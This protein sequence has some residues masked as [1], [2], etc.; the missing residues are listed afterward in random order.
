MR[1][2]T[3]AK[4]DEFSDWVRSLKDRIARVKIFVRARRLANGNMGDVKHIAKAKKLL[5]ASKIASR[6][7]RD[8]RA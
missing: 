7:T 4:T 2:Y 3:V 8:A 6:R 1:I 5:A